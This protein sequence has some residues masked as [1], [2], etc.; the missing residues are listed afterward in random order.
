MNG[1][2][3]RSQGQEIVVSMVH[4][5]RPIAGGCWLRVRTMRART[6]S[7]PVEVDTEGAFGHVDVV[8]ADDGA[9][10]VSWWRRNA[11]GGSEL[12]VR[13]VAADGSLGAIQHVAKSQASRPVDF[14]QMVKSGNGV[15]VAWTEPGAES[16]DEVKTALAAL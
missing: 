13:R 7:A 14:P 15:V 9:A 2:A 16:E 11:S 1:P 10:I 3:L 6:F 8:L 5:A 4:G 12:S